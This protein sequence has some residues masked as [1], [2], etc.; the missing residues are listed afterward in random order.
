[1]EQLLET[2]DQCDG[3][4]REKEQPQRNQSGYGMRVVG[5]ISADCGKCK[6]VGRILTATGRAIR[7]VIRH[8]EAH[9]M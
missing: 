2:C 5:V 1:M 9:G 6:G 3:T 7:D 8:V 4:G